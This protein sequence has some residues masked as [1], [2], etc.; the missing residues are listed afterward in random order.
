[1]EFFERRFEE[2]VGGWFVKIRAGRI[3]WLEG[4]VNIEV[5]RWER[6]FVRRFVEY[7]V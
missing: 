1:M 5:S 4:I 3:F 7:V 6:G 2:L